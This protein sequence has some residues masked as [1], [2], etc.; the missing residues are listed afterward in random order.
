MLFDE[1]LQA[2]AVPLAPARRDDVGTLGFL[3]HLDGVAG[4]ERLHV[5]ASQRRSGV[6]LLLQI[7]QGGPHGRSPGEFHV[8]CIAHRLGGIDV[9]VKKFQVSRACPGP[10]TYA[11]IGSS[12]GRFWVLTNGASGSRFTRITSGRDG[13]VRSPL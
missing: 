7:F 10:H 13:A 9:D 4:A 3:P 12:F 11:A 2:I 5:L 8:R 6:G 1:G